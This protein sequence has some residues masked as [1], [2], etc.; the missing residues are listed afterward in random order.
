EAIE[1]ARGMP[2]M[3][4]HILFL[5]DANGD[6][7]VIERSPSRFVVRRGALFVTNHFLDPELAADPHNRDI[8]RISSTLARFQRLRQLASRIY[9]RDDLTAVLRDRMDA[10]GKP[11]AAGDRRAIDADI[12][13]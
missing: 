5:A 3:V 7:A 13:T 8:E 9:G 1:V 11:L 12:A 10:D 4:S 6:T 2:V